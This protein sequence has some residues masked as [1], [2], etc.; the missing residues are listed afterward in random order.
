MLLFNVINQQPDVDKIYL[1]T[2]DPYEVKHLVLI[3]KHADVGTLHL[4]DS[5]TFIE[6]LLNT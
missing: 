6:Y 2:K 1:D 5:K 4:S 3:K